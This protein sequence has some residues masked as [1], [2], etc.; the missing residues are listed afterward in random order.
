VIHT[1]IITGGRNYNNR[2]FVNRT[3]D[4]VR[5][6]VG[7]VELLMEGGAEGADR[8]ARAWA[9]SRGVPHVAVD[10]DWDT[11]GRRAGVMLRREGVGL[12]VVFPGG[13]GTMNMLQQARTAKMPVLDFSR[14]GW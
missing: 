5:R 14:S 10:A 4:D 9:V 2:T 8:M 11:Y 12:V 3:L 7:G 6:A 1:M 13:A